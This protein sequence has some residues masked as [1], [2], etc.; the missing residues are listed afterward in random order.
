MVYGLLDGIIKLFL[1]LIA[2]GYYSTFYQGY[3]LTIV[4]VLGCIWLL[5]GVWK[6]CQIDVMWEKYQKENNGKR[7]KAKNMGTN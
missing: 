7:R 3:T 6:S 4:S 1:L 5:W 2:L